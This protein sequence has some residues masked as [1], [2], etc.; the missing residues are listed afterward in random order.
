MSTAAKGH[1]RK[2]TGDPMTTE[3]NRYQPSVAASHKR[4]RRS[5]WP[6]RL[7][8]LTAGP[9][10]CGNRTVPGENLSLRMPM[11]GADH[12]DDV[13]VY[14]TLNDGFELFMGYPN[15]WRWHIQRDEAHRLAWFILW[16]WWAKGEWFGLRRWAYYRGLHAHVSRFTGPRR[17]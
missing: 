4:R 2:A 11:R 17:G 10:W 16:T 6:E 8:A 12:P 3:N 14:C 5:S 13:K 9:D 7:M 1:Y 15:E